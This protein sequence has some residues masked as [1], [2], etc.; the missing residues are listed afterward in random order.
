MNVKNMTY[1]NL[2]ITLTA[3]SWWR[4]QSI[5]PMQTTFT[6]CHTVLISPGNVSAYLRRWGQFF[7]ATFIQDKKWYKIIF[8]KIGQGKAQTN[9]RIGS[10]TF[11]WPNVYIVSSVTW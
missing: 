6:N 2:L 5:S 10:A 8:E 11:L 3:S 4:H 9:S 7:S 1:V